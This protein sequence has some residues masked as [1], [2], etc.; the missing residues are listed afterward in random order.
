MEKIKFTVIIPA[1]SG[2]KGIKNKN[3]K[4]F[5]NIPLLVHSINFAK[6]L[7]FVDQIIVSTDSPKFAAIAKKAG[8]EVP[9]LRSK[10]ASKDSSMEEDVLK[11]IK[12]NCIKNKYKINNNL[13]WLRPT[14][15]LR[16]IVDF[17]RAY[18]L[19][20]RYRKS[21]LICAR[22][23][24]RI[25]FSKKN[26]LIPVLKEMK[27]KSMLRRQEA[28]VAYKIFFGE[29]FSLYKKINKNFLG[30]YKLF[31]ETS[32]LCSIDIDNSNDLRFHEE[33]IKKNKKKFSRFLHI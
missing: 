27:Y 6:K 23:D 9:F 14:S 33:Y 3:I 13:L 1:R 32:E 15:P 4:Y 11:D 30:K 24:S 8:A 20:C 31:V 12:I 22:T 5:L 16:N 28:P 26:R 7:K 25:F 10:L 17:K 18:N 29:F 2:S 19:F 21:V